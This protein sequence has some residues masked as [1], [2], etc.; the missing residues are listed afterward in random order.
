[1]YDDELRRARETMK[2][3]LK[4]ELGE[5]VRVSAACRVVLCRRGLADMLVLGCAKR[6]EDS[7]RKCGDE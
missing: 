7:Q 3:S 6:I 5:E 4:E 1:M 2:E